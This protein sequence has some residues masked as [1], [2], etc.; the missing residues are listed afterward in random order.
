MY[1]TMWWIPRHV[2]C[3]PKHVVGCLIVCTKAYKVHSV[4]VGTKACRVCAKA[5][6]VCAKA[7]AVYEDI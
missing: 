4:V 3:V 2:G 1:R 5:C 6:R 7:C